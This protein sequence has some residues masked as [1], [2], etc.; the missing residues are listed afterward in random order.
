MSKGITMISEPSTS[1]EKTLSDSS[2]ENIE[3]KYEY[4]YWPCMEC[5][6]KL[7]ICSKCGK[8]GRY[9]DTDGRCEN[10]QVYPS[11]SCDGHTFS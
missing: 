8:C 6:A 1:A 4:K 2:G 7:V 11:M 9:F 5:V 10:T 3:T